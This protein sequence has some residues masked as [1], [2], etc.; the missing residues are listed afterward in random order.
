MQKGNY[1]N[2]ATA[3]GGQGKYPLSTQTLDFIQQQ[4][5]LL[6]QLGFIGGNKYIL[7]QPD[8]TQTGLAFIDGE[9]FY[10]GCEAYAVG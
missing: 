10:A 2:T 8:G 1:T 7:R 6:Q 9:L 5:T 4:I 3:S